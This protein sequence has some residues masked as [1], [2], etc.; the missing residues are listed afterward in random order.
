M[1]SDTRPTQLGSDHLIDS[2]LLRQLNAKKEVLVNAY[3]QIAQALRFAAKTCDEFQAL[4]PRDVGIIPSDTNTSAPSS[5]G[6]SSRKFKKPQNKDPNAPKRP[7]TAYIL[8]SNEIRAETKVDNPHANQ[9]EIVTLIGKKW[10]ALSREQKKVYEDRYF[11]DKERYDEELRLYRATHGQVDSPPETSSEDNVDHSI[12]SG[13]ASSSK[14]ATT[15]I[16]TTENPVASGSISVPPPDAETNAL[17][18][19]LTDAFLTDAADPNVFTSNTEIDQPETST[20][21]SS[22]KRAPP[23]ID[24]ED[25]S[26]KDNDAPASKR[27]RAASRKAMETEDV[28]NPPNDLENTAVEQPSNTSN[29]SKRTTRARRSAANNG[30]AT[31]Q[32]KAGTPGTPNVRTRRGGKV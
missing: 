11:A 8:F 6:H 3:E 14:Q 5:V 7:N 19:T 29:T 30:S 31:T 2:E 27:T 4:I 10:K 25:N 22:K 15:P 20:S 18:D 17:M 1:P 9:K 13:A 26:K 16:P 28:F 32:S 24:T 23:E 12:V 21:T